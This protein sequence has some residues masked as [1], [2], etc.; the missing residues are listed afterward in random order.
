M[1]V[2]HR[3]RFVFV[4]T[5]KVASSS[6]EICLS[7][8]LTG[9]DFATPQTERDREAADKPFQARFFHGFDRV[10]LP[11]WIG[12]HSPLSQAY[13]RFGP[14][15]A[16]YTVVTAE[17]NPWDRAV[18]LFY[19][20]QRKSDMRER[21][22]DEQVAA[23][24]DYVRRN[25]GTAGR[26]SW[27]QRLR[28]GHRALSQRDLY[29]LDGVPVADV[30]LRQECLTEDLTALSDTL[31]LD[32]PLDLSGIRAKTGYRAEASRDVATFYD[33]ET[34]AIVAA[35]CAWEIEALGYEFGTG[36]THPYTPDP[37]RVGVRRAY[38]ARV[39]RAA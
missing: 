30:I 31:G 35:A 39:G 36:A 8:L 11:I 5:R 3:H 17:R 37:R 34:R 2:S 21:P 29:S 25:G 32:Q 9:G 20:S 23:F 13:R 26:G 38:A 10:G 12:G 22:L 4:R 16:D 18:S 14:G 33:D 6:L 27:W 7:Q 15:I 24:R 1:I 19:W 28:H